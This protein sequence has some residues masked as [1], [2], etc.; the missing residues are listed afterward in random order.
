[1]RIN[2]CKFGVGVLL[3]AISAGIVQEFA[4][5]TSAPAQ[6]RKKD[7]SARQKTLTVG[8]SEDRNLPLPQCRSQNTDNF[9]TTYLVGSSGELTPGDEK[10]IKNDY[11]ALIIPKGET[12]RAKEIRRRALEYKQGKLDKIS[13]SY[14]IWLKAHPN[15][16]PA[17][18]E[19][20]FELQQ[21]VLDYYTNWFKVFIAEKRWD[22]REQGVNLGPV[23]Y[24]GY[25]CNTCWAFAAADAASTSLQIARWKSRRVS[26][27][28]GKDGSITF[29]SSWWEYEPVSSPF[30]QDLLNCMPISAKEICDKGWHGKAFNFMV[31]KRGMP[32]AAAE[33]YTEEDQWGNLITF[34]RINEPW[35]KF[36]CQPKFDFKKAVSWDYVNYPPDLMPTVEQL[37]TALIEHGPLVAP[38]IVDNCL[39]RYK[40]GVFNEK[41]KGK[42]GH[43][44]LLVGWDD[45]KGAWLVKNSWGEKWGEKG[46][47]WIKYGSNEIGMFAAWIES[48][49]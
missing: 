29:A 9:E 14:E 17:Q 48:E 24:Q 5:S 31:Y 6:N 4:Q 37:K 38:M 18:I 36:P 33:G 2:N 16:T 34:P 41:T 23:L 42:I 44:V 11:G 15:A 7:K 49:N 12:K 25:L 46:Y 45:A 8:K 22:W 1:M 28:V 35:K 43:V 32:M 40:S 27:G 26:Y 30:V 21:F 3:L 19:A 13:K 47:G 10:R 20:R 39:L